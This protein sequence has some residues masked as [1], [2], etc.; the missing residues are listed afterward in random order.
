MLLDADWR[1]RHCYVSVFQQDIC[2]VRLFHNFLYSISIYP[3]QFSAR[4]DF[5]S[6]IYWFVSNFEICP[7]S[8]QYS[9]W[10]VFNVH[11]WNWR[12]W[13][14]LKQWD[15]QTNRTLLSNI[16]AV[17]LS[18]WHVRKREKYELYIFFLMLSFFSKKSTELSCVS[19]QS[20][21]SGL[22]P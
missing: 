10:K 11:V 22:T 1:N 8:N 9:G 12:G 13:I 5:N 14:Y 20:F 19:K 7:I 21:K 4:W 17:S 15:Q 18:I 16:N 3:W 6:W 2:H